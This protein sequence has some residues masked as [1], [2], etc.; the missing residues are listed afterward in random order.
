MTVALR[1]R[2]YGGPILVLC[3][4]LGWLAGSAK[5]AQVEHQQVVSGLH[6]ATLE[7]RIDPEGSATTC[8][9]EYV[10]QEAYEEG[11]ESWGAATTVACEPASLGAGTGPVAATAELDGLALST[12]Y[13]YRFA[14]EAGG[15]ETTGAEGEFATFGVQGFSFRT[16]D[17]AGEPETQAGAHPYEL[18]TRIEAPTTQVEGAA[19]KTTPTGT[20][21]DIIDELPPGLIGNPTAVARCSAR[22]AEENECSGD[23]QVG[24]LE[25]WWAEKKEDNPFTAALYNTVAPEGTAARFIGEING[26]TDG[27]IDSSVRSGQDYGITSG[28]LN[29]SGRTNVFRV[30][31]RLWGVPASPLHDAS[32]SCP[33]LD[34]KHRLETGCS[35]TLPE[36]PFLRNPTSCE[37]PLEARVKMDAYQGPLE[38][39]EGSTTLPAMT[40]CG[41]IGFDRPGLEPTIAVTPTSRVN[42]S[43]TGLHVDLHVP[44]NEEPEGLATPDLK[45]AVVKL[46]AGFTV[47]PS[48]ANGL[49]GCTRTQFGLETAVGVT[50]IETTPGPAECPESSKIGTVEVDTPLLDHP[51]P[52][53]VYVA[54][55]YQNPFDSLLAIYI[56]VYD[57]VSGVVIKLAGDIEIGAEGQLTTRF[58]EN[59][60][61]PFEDFKLDFFGGELAALKTPA[62]C[63]TG[64]TEATLT[65]WAAPAAGSSVASTDPSR[66][67]QSVTGGSCPTSAGA[68]PTSVSF[69]AGSESPLAGAFSPFVVHLSRP[70]GSQQ[71]S[72]LTVTPPPGLLGSLAGIPYCSD[73][74]LAS[75]AAESG[76]EERQS[77]S[78][79]EAS[80]VGS[81][82]VGAGAGPRPY[83]TSGTAYLAGPYKGAPLSLAIVT[84]AVA[85]PYDLG[86][87]VV[88]A[89]LV[90]N[91]KT[92]QITVE[93]DPIPTE[94]KGIPLDVRSI[95]VKMD[96]QGFTVN[97]TS[98]EVSAV[99]GS[100]TTVQGQTVPLSNRF[101]VGGC[102]SLPFKPRLAIRV[103]GKTNRN[104]KPRLR[105]VL[106]TKS[107]EANIRR[108]QVNLPHSLF[109]EQS[110]IRTNCTRV[111]W[112]EGNGNGSACPKGSIY[113]HA[114]AF[115]PL[116]D[117]PLEGPV[118]LRSS[119]HKL[120]DLVAALDGQI[121]VELDAKIDSGKNDGLRTTFEFVPDAPV[122]KFI[123][124]M[125]GGGRG[126]LVNSEPLCTKKAKRAAIARFVGQNGKVESFK[127]RV[128]ASCG[129]AKGKTKQKRSS[130]HHRRGAGS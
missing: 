40:G 14:L 66:V 3:L 125:K 4:L 85:G 90:V 107:G 27:T 96:R 79:P 92:T 112:A 35:S 19:S 89:A 88:R 100:L 130:S 34:G 117:E 99:G 61:L 18:V 53:A 124:E 101:Q 46:P 120:P 20:I 116:L 65:S 15:T 80:K 118:Y 24:I 94:L 68:E 84:P 115:S 78:C 77:P 57:P 126:L 38:W 49:T 114:R 28:G 82:V 52:G 39:S 71:F 56:G 44:Q 45:D 127:P 95:T 111:Q 87:V 106:Q 13:R 58:D 110:H 70:D 8:S 42:D 97:P 93:S 83:Y 16:V 2:L 32:R 59:P 103:F 76:T 67:D 119:S 17:A 55:P 29:I 43:P 105:A 109:L 21:K 5:A 86:D 31:V 48:S 23:A 11:G 60:R 22:S 91:K 113:G 122:S 73:A 81:V 33:I 98:C 9:A 54:Q 51:L 74:A 30:Q 26:S 63:G 37:G 62:A 50:P 69:E 7:A 12:T 64:E 75:A 41:A 6:T 25:V 121:D 10:S 102:R 47:N 104:A 72:S 128:A 108:A 129:S 123:L 1:R 36:R